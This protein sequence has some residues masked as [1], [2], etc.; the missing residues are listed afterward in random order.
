MRSD[1]GP[2]VTEL[3]VST[4]ALRGLDVVL[5]D[6]DILLARLAGQVAA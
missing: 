6:L 5:F 3:C 1:F 4:A 2:H